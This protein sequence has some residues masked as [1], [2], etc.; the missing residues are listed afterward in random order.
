ME[1]THPGLG[2]QFSFIGCAVKINPEEKT[3]LVILSNYPSGAKSKEELAEAY[4]NHWPNLEEAFQDYSRKIEL[5][6]YTANSQRFFSAETLNVKMDS[7]LKIVDLL[8]AYLLVLD[9]YVRWHL[10][11]AGFEDKDILFLKEKFYGLSV[12]LD[13]DNM[14]SLVRFLLPP[15]YPLAKELNYALHRVNEKEASLSGGL[16]LYLSVP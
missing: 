15:G 4:L 6:T 13:K 8:K 7:A 2:K 3:R 9:A 1:I 14:S 10:L 16:R 11:P 5:F 12:T